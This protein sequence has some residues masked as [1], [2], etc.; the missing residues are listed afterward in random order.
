MKN[1]NYP[2]KE[3]QHLANVVLEGVRKVSVGM[4]TGRWEVGAW[5]LRLDKGKTG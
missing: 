2:P 3:L 1:M 4:N 5:N